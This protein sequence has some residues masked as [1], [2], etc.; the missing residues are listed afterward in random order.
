MAWTDAADPNAT[1]AN[2]LAIV[3]TVDSAMTYD[4]AMG[5]IAFALFGATRVAPI[6]QAEGRCVVG[7]YDHGQK[8]EH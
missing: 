8:S 6:S 7:K 4:D 2:T 3:E 5:A 1:A